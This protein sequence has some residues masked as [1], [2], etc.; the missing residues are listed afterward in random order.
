[1]KRYRQHRPPVRVQGDGCSY[2]ISGAAQKTGIDQGSAISREFG[3]KG[4][5]LVR[6]VGKSGNYLRLQ[7]CL[8]R[9]GCGGK[10]S[11]GSGPGN[12][13][14]ESGINGDSVAD[15]RKRTIQIG[16]IIE[17]CSRGIHACD[18]GVSAAIGT[19]LAIGDRLECILD[20][21]VRGAGKT[22]H[23]NAVLRVQRQPPD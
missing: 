11:G 16:R 13:S 5:V 18:K 3:N 20:G 2:I 22:G 8:K 7:R 6:I 19:I 4:V 23:V 10:V 15:T 21:E 9:A 12:V 17:V 1:M 14:L